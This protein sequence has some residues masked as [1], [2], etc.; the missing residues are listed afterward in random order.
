[1]A[2]EARPMGHCTSDN[3]RAPHRSGAQ[4]DRRLL[5]GWPESGHPCDDGWADPEPARWLNLQAHPVATVTLVKESRPVRARAAEGDE[6]SRLWAT[7]R[8][9]DRQLDDNA[10][11]RSSQTVVILERRSVPS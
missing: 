9:I 1:L 7:W 6:R 11:M 8:D 2:P 3:N 10:A 5:R 4:R